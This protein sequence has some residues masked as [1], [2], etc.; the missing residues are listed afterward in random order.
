[1][2]FLFKNSKKNNLKKVYKKT[3]KMTLFVNSLLKKYKREKMIKRI[4]KFLGF[5]R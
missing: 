1:M 2:I 3:T 4:K 5:K